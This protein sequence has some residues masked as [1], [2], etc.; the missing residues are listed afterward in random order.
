MVGLIRLPDSTK[1]VCSQGALTCL[2][3]VLVGVVPSAR[4]ANDWTTA[5]T[6]SH[7]LTEL[8]GSQNAIQGVSWLLLYQV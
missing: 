5:A 8:Y 2:Q 6:A 1:V 7:M 3:A 4:A